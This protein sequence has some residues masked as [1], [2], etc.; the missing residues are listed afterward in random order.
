MNKDFDFSEIGKRTPFRT[1]EGFFEKMQ[2][3]TLKRVTE[4]KRKTKLYRLKW[5]VSLALAAA[6]MLCGFLFL[7]S[8]QSP[9]THQPSSTNWVAQTYGNDEMDFYL[10][11]LTDEELEAWIEFSENDVFYEVTTTNLDEDEN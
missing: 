11:E 4:E 3:E 8:T 5:G 9:D 1:P 2:A 6:A 10:Q 7:P